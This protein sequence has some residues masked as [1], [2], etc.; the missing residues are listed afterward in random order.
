[1]SEFERTRSAVPP[2]VPSAR[3]DAFV[4]DEDSA[5]AA[6]PDPAFVREGL[7][8]GFRMRHDAHYVDQL[9]SRTPAPQVRFIPI[10]DIDAAKPGD[11][12]DLAPLVRS[13]QKFGVLQPVLVRP[14]A[15][16]FE[17]IAG[18]R[19][20]A[21]AAT[22]ALT[23]VPCMVHQV[24]DLKARALAEAE[25]IGAAVDPRA[26]AAPVAIAPVPPAPTPSHA[27]AGLQEL[28]QSF[29]AIGS[30]LHLLAERDTALRDRV[31]LDLVR[32]EV[33]RASRLVQGLRL[34]AQ[35]PTLSET[36]VSLVTALDQ[37]AEGFVPERRLSGV[38]LTIEPADGAHRVHADPEWL[39]MG[40]S[41]ALGGMLAFVQTAR[42]ASLTVKISSSSSGSSVMLQIAQSGVTVPAW[43]IGR[44]FDTEWTERPGGFQAAVELAAARRVA[45]LHHG[46]L[47]L[48]TGDR[49]GCKLVLVLPAE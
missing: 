45:E 27:T 11:A 47:E 22:A 43:A 18:A 24:D 48:V 30:C 29:G 34:L 12:R 41:C 38:S 33:H 8:A 3:P 44:F 20:L 7:P 6:F 21:A 42:S 28:S 17:L 23:E 10:G 4:P 31:A 32:T 15:G 36:G 16:R 14:R 25:N 39:A 9:T 1:V 49:G 46:G 40:L 19:R 5:A 13:I 26:P 35:D 2:F 37:V